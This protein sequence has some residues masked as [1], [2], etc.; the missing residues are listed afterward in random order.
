MPMHPFV[1]V[2]MIVQVKRRSLM[3]YATFPS[4]CTESHLRLRPVLHRLQRLQREWRLR[5][6]IVKDLV[7]VLK[8]GVDHPDLPASIGDVTA[9]A[10]P[11]EGR[12]ED[13]GEVLGA[14]PVDT[15]VLDHTVE[16]ER[17]ST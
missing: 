17:E 4:L 16:V 12:A 10:G 3:S 11:H 6:I 13:D 15:R 2:L 5:S 7:G 9:A 14:H 8:N 1:Y